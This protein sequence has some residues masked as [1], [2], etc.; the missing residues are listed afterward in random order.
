MIE[1]K[2]KKFIKDL[3]YKYTGVIKSKK[4]KKRKF[5]IISNNCWGGII[6]RNYHIQYQTP[7]CGLFFMAPEY[8]KFIYNIKEYIYENIIEISVDDS[9]YKEYL[10]EIKYNGIIGKIKDIE[11]CFLHYSDIDEINDK[12]KRRVK[13]IDWENIIYKFNDQNLCTYDDLM[14]FQNLDVNNKIC[15]TAHKY[16][17]IDTIQL[18]KYKNKKCVIDD[19]KEKNYKKYINI[20]EYINNM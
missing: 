5:T 10:L 12:W 2:W 16:K 17:D 19:T 4:L 3:F 6:Y 9:K 20:V 15:F 11:I 18:E 1:N 14:A 7:T 8:I 13:R